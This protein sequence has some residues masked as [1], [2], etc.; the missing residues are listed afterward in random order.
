M[1]IV[2]MGT[3]EFAVPALD[4]LLR[5]GFQVPAVVTAT[6]K[7][8]GRGN[9][10]H[11]SAVKQFAMKHKIPVLQPEKL[12]DP[13]FLGALQD[14]RADVFAVVAFRMLPEQVISIPRLGAVNLHASLLPDYRGAAP[15]QHALLQGETVTGVTTFFI[16]HAIDTGD[17]IF[18]QEIPIHPDEDAGQLHDRLMIAGAKLLV[19]TMEALESGIF[20]RIPQPPGRNKTAPKIYRNDCRIHWDE[21]ILKIY[22][23]IRGL[24]PY[25]GAWTTFEGH[26]LKILRA[27]KET[28]THTL[29]PGTYSVTGGRLRYAAKDGFIYPLIVQ[30]EGKNKMPAED[31]IRGIQNKKSLHEGR[32]PF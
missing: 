18:R 9:K 1:R 30:A 15:I 25:P 24:S 16:R 29:A 3:P 6:D 4:V 26:S 11:M 7:P 13:Q 32:D 10:V 2:F 28:A 14:L 12:R 31:F 5:A 17:I 23:F 21:P 8:A 20:P 27:E 22:N 19:K